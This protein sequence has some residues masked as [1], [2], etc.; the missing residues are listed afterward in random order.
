MKEVP[1]ARPIAPL[2]DEFEIEIGEAG[3][4]WH[5]SNGRVGLTVAPAAGDP[6]ARKRLPDGRP[7]LIH[8]INAIKKACTPRAHKVQWAVGE[9]AGV[10]VYVQDR[11]GRVTI[12]LTTEELNP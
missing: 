7:V 3:R 5:A 9:L 12:L 11:D 4:P 1:T 6:S 2:A 8:K 10:K